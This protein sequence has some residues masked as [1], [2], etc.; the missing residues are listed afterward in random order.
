MIQ[1]CFNQY[2]LKKRVFPK[3][4]GKQPVVL[5]FQSIVLHFVFFE[6]D[7]KSLT[8]FEFAVKPIQPVVL[9]NQPIDFFEN[10]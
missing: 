10:P 5:S 6:K 9:R 4:V 2:L 7:L 8:L 1:T 3:E